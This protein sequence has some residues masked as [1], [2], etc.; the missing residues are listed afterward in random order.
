MFILD[1]RCFFSIS[2]PG[3]PILIFLIPDPGSNNNEIKGGEILSYLFV[4]KLSKI[5]VLW[6]WD[7]YPGS[8]IRLF[9]IPDPHQRIY[10]SI[11]PQKM[12]SKL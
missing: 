2:G 11:L 1:P 8:P 5:A 6:I 12:V 7:I 4:Q 9:S 10:V 3:F